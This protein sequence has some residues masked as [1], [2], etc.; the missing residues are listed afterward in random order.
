V[1]HDNSISNGQ[2]HSSFRKKTYLLLHQGDFSKREDGS[3][4]RPV[5]VLGTRIVEVLC[6]DDEGGK[7]DS[8]AGAIHAWMDQR[9]Q[10]SATGRRGGGSEER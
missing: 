8:M 7:E 1:A 2:T 5:L 4:T 6:S 9:R 10:A 3:V